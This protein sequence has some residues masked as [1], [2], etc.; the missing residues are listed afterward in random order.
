MYFT[1]KVVSQ[2]EYEQFVAENT[3][4]E[5]TATPTANATATPT[6]NVTPDTNTTA[7]PTDSATATPTA[8]PA[9]AVSPFRV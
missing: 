7:T 1:V 4:S 2:E 6:G 5:T 9:A 3:A 8:T